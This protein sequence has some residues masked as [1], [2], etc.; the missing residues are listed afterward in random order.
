MVTS[1]T[2]FGR[3]E[4]EADGVKIIAELRSV[5]H[6]FCEVSI[7]TPKF[8]NPLELQFKQFVQKFIQR[9]Q[10][11]LYL[12]WDDDKTKIE[13]ITL[14]E[15]TVD[16]YHQMLLDL[17]NKYQLPGEID[18]KI[19]ASMPDL[20]KYET[21]EVDIDAAFEMATQAITEAIY[22]LNRMREK[23]GEQLADD[24]RKRIE[25]IEKNLNKIEARAP[26]RVKEAKIT[27]EQR[28]QSLLETDV[29]D[30]QRLAMEIAIFAERIDI[31]EECVRFH[32][33]NKQFLNLLDEGGVIGKK[34]N[35]LLQEMHREINTIGAKANDSKII[36]DVIQIKEEIEKMREQVQNI[37]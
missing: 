20:L 6:R 13:K 25:Q 24:L 29:V 3:A 27:L 16:I 34:L 2:G 5:N 9:G 26:E 7:R 14:N 1:M 18:L 28:I 15:E 4:V 37:A 12:S 30:P 31:T 8:L 22:D 33:H 35:F 23:E 17:K 11:S 32:S 10:V 19:L 21:E 36:E